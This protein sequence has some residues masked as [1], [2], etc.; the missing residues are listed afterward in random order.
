MSKQTECQRFI[1]KI[2]SSRLR[3]SK[4]RLTLPLSEARKNGEVISLASSQMLRWIDE[5]NGVVDADERAKRIKA[6]IQALKKEPTSAANKKA[7]RGLYAALDNLQ[8]KPD[9]MCLIIDSVS[10]Y[11]R[12]CKGFYINGIKYGRLLGTTGGIKMSTIVFANA[13]L[14]PEL[15]KRIDNGRKADMAFV[16][17]KLEAYRALTCS[18]SVP[19]S[20]PRGILVVSDVET[21]FDDEVINLS[22]EGDGEPTMSE[23]TVQKIKLTP[24]DGCGMILPSLAEKWSSELGLDYLMS[25]CCVRCAFTKGM[26]FT[27]PFDEFA[28]LRA[29]LAVNDVGAYIVKD[30]WG[31]EVDVREV[32]MVLTTSMLKL[33]DSYDSIDDYISKCRENHYTFAVTKACPKELE[34]D[35]CLNYQFT[36]SYDLS[37]AEIEELIAPTVEEF[38]DVLGGDWRKAVLFLSGDGLNEKNV[39]KMN[40]DYIKALMVEPSVTNDPYVR[41]SIYQLVKNRINEAKVSVI[42]VHGN[43]SMMSGD[44]Y[45]LCQHIFG[46]PL[47]GLLRAGEIY[48]AYW[49]RVYTERDIEE[50]V[51]FRAPMSVHSNIRKLRVATRDNVRHWFRYMQS[52]TVM[53]AW[54]NEMNAMNGADL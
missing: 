41:K 5:L 27:F 38:N 47:T 20:A 7:I 46:E 42:H 36:Q 10:D 16:P 8:F 4:W 14:L 13:E 3:Q 15:R 21:E 23:P 48:N 33:W 52:C 50:V 22:N 11:R 39:R 43:Y 2:H 49:D 17:A 44:L 32:D 35:R 12:A 19:V 1:M 30:A 18:A 26:L 45:L 37:D 29:G 53:S 51:G 54:S 6:E 31:N 40:D 34:S 9:Y 28:E 25:G 24:S